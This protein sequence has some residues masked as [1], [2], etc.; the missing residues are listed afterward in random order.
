MKR[1]LLLCAVFSLI[2]VSCGEKKADESKSPALNPQQE[3]ELFQK[4]NTIFGKLPDKM[5]GS[6]NDTPELIAL[7]KK[8]YF[9]K[10]ISG[11]G[12]QACNSCHDI[13]TKAGVDG[14]PVSPGAF[15]GKSGTRNSP[16]VLNAGF[17]FVQFWDGRAKDLKE[18]AK[19]PILNPVEMSMLS[20]KDVEKVISANAEYKDMFAK[21]YPGNPKPVTYDNLAN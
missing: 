15:D 7:G 12:K 9:E 10:S 4:A 2:L 8:L 11:N 21:A 16:T 13:D 18:Q 1:F 17:Q 20:E 19:G 14:L 3:A 6:E 5:P